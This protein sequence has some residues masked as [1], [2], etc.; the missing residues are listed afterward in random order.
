MDFNGVLYK[1]ISECT[2]N[3]IEDV[4]S[5]VIGTFGILFNIGDVFIQTAAEKSEFEFDNIDNPAKI[6]DII[7]DLVVEARHATADRNNN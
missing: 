6:R 5:N 4:T 1:N 7:S 2:L 3:N